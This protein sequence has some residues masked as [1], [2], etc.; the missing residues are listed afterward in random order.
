M[1]LPE[2]GV[3]STLPEVEAKTLVGTADRADL[4]ETGGDGH[5]GRIE[6]CFFVL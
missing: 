3:L 5:I 6:G 2:L 1:D 4:V